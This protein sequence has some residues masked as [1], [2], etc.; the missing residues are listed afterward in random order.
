MKWK[1]RF[2]HQIVIILLHTHQHIDRS[3]YIL[4]EMIYKMDIKLYNI[5]FVGQINSSL[6]LL[7]LYIS[8]NLN[9]P[10]EYFIVALLWLKKFAK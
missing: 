9:F 1:F 3:F 10:M 5:Q 7:S 2:L 4:L 8:G 6:L